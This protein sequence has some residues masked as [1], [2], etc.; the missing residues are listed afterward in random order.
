MRTNLIAGLLLATT[1]VAFAQDINEIRVQQTGID[2]QIYAEIKGVAGTDL[3]TYTL[4][5]IGNDDFATPPAQN[6]YIESAIQLSGLIPAS[7]YYVVAEPS[8]TLTTPDLFSF[9]DIQADN[10]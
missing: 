10:N 9:L 2:T 7:G 6:G 8:Y 4:I 1:S 3:S 5:V